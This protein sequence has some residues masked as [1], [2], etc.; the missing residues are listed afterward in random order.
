[1]YASFALLSPRLAAPAR[2][3]ACVLF[4]VVFSLT[5]LS[6]AHAQVAWDSG[7][8]AVVL[9]TGTV[10]VYAF[11]PDPL[12]N[13]YVQKAQLANFAGSNP[14]D[15]S[16]DADGF[17]WL[18]HRSNNE[19]IRIASDGAGGG[20]ALT[21]I[22]HGTVVPPSS[23]PITRPGR[24]TFGIDGLSPIVADLDRVGFSGPVH[25]YD[26]SGSLGQAGVLPTL[27]GFGLRGLDVE[28]NGA[29]DLSA[30]YT[31]QQL[32]G[33]FMA[34]PFLS[35]S[36][37]TLVASAGPNPAAVR[38]LPT[39][40]DGNRSFLVAGGPEPGGVTSTIRLYD[41]DSGA[42]S[43]ALT[44]SFDVPDPQNWLT[45]SLTSDGESFW[46]GSGR[47]ESSTL[48]HFD[49]ATGALLET[50]TGVIDPVN[51][52]SAINA[53]TINGGF[54]AAQPANEAPM[55]VAACEQLT[56][57]GTVAQVRLDA[58][59]SSDPDG[60]ELTFDWTISSGGTT[61][62][63]C[64]G[65]AATCGTIETSL[66][67]GSYLVTLRVTDPSGL[68]DENSKPLILDPASLSSLDSEKARVNFNNGSL[69]LKGEI[70]LPSGVDFSE[71]ASVAAVSLD[72][73]D[74]ALATLET[75]TLVPQ[76]TD[77]R[78]WRFSDDV[79]IGIVRFNIDWR[80]ARYSFREAQFPVRF[81]SQVITSS[82]TI[83]TLRLRPRQ[84]TDPFTIDF[85]G[86]ASVSVDAEGNVTADPSV[87]VEVEKPGREYTLTLPLPLLD[88]STIVFGGGIDR[89]LQVVDDLKASVGR[90]RL[91]YCF[92][93]AGF[94][95]GSLTTPREIQ[96]E[97]LLGAQSYPGS[98][99][100]EELDLD[101]K[102]NK[103][104]Q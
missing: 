37:A 67:F 91:L 83:L 85:D 92:D 50:I 102:G 30:I 99:L 38:F 19:T 36:A 97:L 96:L 1:M 100:L 93:P 64:S 70:G 62:F 81:R 29:G 75:V 44:R 51:Q 25:E 6:V 59:D 31:V 21:T 68:F 5:G 2:A 43:Y 61:V 48:Y 57:I 49:I 79:P 66:D 26:S 82:E 76:G 60:D 56:N 40:V 9:N 28:V 73:S 80:G 58:S 74:T 10:K 32:G 54:R 84:I 52:L 55:G 90:Y 63:T 46:T 41:F 95:D 53:V 16:F 94:P 27:S 78:R 39:V 23:P 71:I 15:A 47:T 17:L 11:D 103:W 34:T 3:L 7:D 42:G 20:I 45:L 86:L 88:T 12:V 8:I 22:D 87:E 72:L 89:T 98:V 14:Q 69:Q 18:T 104:K 35:G 101:V 4:A 77:G 13:A 65:D 33:V 24:L